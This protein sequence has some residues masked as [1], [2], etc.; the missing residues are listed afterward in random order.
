MMIKE[1]EIH[2]YLPTCIIKRNN[3]YVKSPKNELFFQNFS[4]YLTQAFGN[5]HETFPFEF[6]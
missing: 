1:M 4:V 6:M 3:F 2:I 5:K